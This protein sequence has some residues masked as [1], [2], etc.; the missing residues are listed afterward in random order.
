M[1][2]V[3]TDDGKH[4]NDLKEHIAQ[5]V[6]LEYSEGVAALILLP[7]SDYIHLLPVQKMLLFAE[8]RHVVDTC[9]HECGVL[10]IWM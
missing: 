1:Y 9:G 6:V 8:D 5:S 3:K 2:T 4:A 10:R 7:P